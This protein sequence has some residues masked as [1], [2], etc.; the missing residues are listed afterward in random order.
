MPFENNYHALLGDYSATAACLYQIQVAEQGGNFAGHPQLLE[1]LGL[2]NQDL[3]RRL[4][5]LSSRVYTRLQGQALPQEGPDIHGDFHP[6]DFSVEDY[7][8]GQLNDPMATYSLRFQAVLTHIEFF[9][10]HWPLLS[11]EDLDSLNA[12]LVAVLDEYDVI[13]EALVAAGLQQYA[14]QTSF[15]NSPDLLLMAAGSEG[16]DGTAAGIHLRWDFH[17]EL[18]RNHLPKGDYHNATGNTVGFNRPD[19]YVRL[20]RT[21]YVD[22]VQL[23]LDLEQARPVI[24]WARRRWTYIIN[25]T[26]AGKVLSSRI[27]LTFNDANEYQALAQVV[28]PAQE[29]YTFLQAYDGLLEITLH[30]KPAYR[31]GVQF[32]KAPGAPT[33]QFKLELHSEM[34]A[35]TEPAI[36]IRKT[37]STAS[38][39]TEY[40]TGDNLY[41]AVLQKTA[42][43]SLQKLFIENYH[44]FKASRPSSSW[45]TLGDGFALSVHDSTV[46][47][48]LENSSFTIN[49][50]WPQ[51][52]GGTKVLSSSYRDKWNLPGENPETDP[53]LKT[54]VE[55]Y[56]LLSEKDPRAIENW[57]DTGSDE[58]IHSIK[59][60]YL[61]L[62]K[63][64]ALD[65]HMARMLGMGYIDTLPEAADGQYIYQMQYLT[66]KSAGA[67]ELTQHE[68]MSLPTGPSDMRLPQV[69]RIR[70]LQYQL[71]AG[72]GTENLGNVNNQGYAADYQV[73]VVNIGREH[74]SE[75]T[76][77]D[78]F[79]T[80]DT[81]A[82]YD[83]F[84]H[85]RPVMY[86]IEYRKDEQLEYVKPEI[87]AAKMSGEV[88]YAYDAA[89]A[90]PHLVPETIP[91]MDNPDSLFV[92]LVNQ[93][94]I[95][96][97]ALYGINL[98]SRASELSGETATDTT[99]FPPQNTL[100]PPVDLTAQYIQAEETLLFTTA[101]EQAWLKG[102]RNL[103][104]EGEQDTHFTRICFNHVDVQEITGSLPEDVQ[105][106]DQVQV[107]FR[108]SQPLEIKGEVT[109]LSFLPDSSGHVVVHTGGYEQLDGLSISPAIAPA[110]FSRFRDSILTTTEGQFRVIAVSS[111]GTS[112]PLLTVERILDREAI[113]V[114]SD[115]NRYAAK[116]VLR[117]PL[118]GSRF[119]L[120]ENMGNYAN[121]TTLTHPINLL[122]LSDPDQPVIEAESTGRNTV[123]Y[124]VG[125]LHGPALVVPQTDANN[126]IM[127]G[128]FRVTYQP[129]I[130][131]PTHPQL[132]PPYRDDQNLPSAPESGSSPH[133][134][135]YKGVLRLATQEN[136]AP[137]K[138]L[139]VVRILS[140]TPK[141]TLLAYDPLPE[142]TPIQQSATDIDYINGVNFHPGYRAYL[143][144]EAAPHSFNQ[145]HL[146]PESSA[147]D[148]RTLLGVQT[149]NTQYG[150][151]SG[152]SSP[153]ILLA[154]QIREPQQ[155]AA[156]VIYGAKVRPDASGKASF[157]FDTPMTD[158]IAGNRPKPFGMV[159]YRTHHE[160]VLHALYTD[161]TV[162]NILN[163]TVAYTAEQYLN[164]I[165]LTALPEVIGFPA[166][167][168]PGI[169]PEG[170]TAEILLDR[171][172]NAIRATLMP[173]TEQVPMLDYVNTGYQT[174]NTQPVIR[175][176]DGGL[177]SPNDPAFKPFPM[178]RLLPDNSAIRFTDYN[179]NASARFWYFYASAE[180]TMELTPGP[181]STFAGPISVLQTAALPVPTIR[182]VEMQAGN[183]ANAAGLAINFHLSA[184]SNQDAITKLR[185]YRTADIN[186]LQTFP[187]QASFIEV[188]WPAG[189]A[190]AVTDNLVDVGPELLGKTLYY[191]LVAIR[192]IINEHEELEDI[193]SAGSK[194]IPVQ[195][196]D[197][198][199]PE[200][201]ILTYDESANTL[202]WQP[203][204]AIAKYSLYQQNARG[205]WKLMTVIATTDLEAVTYALPQPLNWT[206]DEGRALYYRFKVTVENSSGLRNTSDRVLTL[207]DAQV[208]N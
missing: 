149:R 170:A 5:I 167:D 2:F 73:R 87:T 106:P 3:M 129:G 81:A 110:D 141:L 197:T 102:R 62:L 179:L 168:K 161:S 51:Y 76:A 103:W 37:L 23:I 166:P 123:Q 89:A 146:L 134:E 120:V 32:S 44:D 148:K 53:A 136:G 172:R 122:D 43:S 6:L 54:L 65:Y 185:L 206:D 19:D 191:Q 52:N 31:F 8:A 158:V 119:T 91:V 183:E 203:T 12:A 42:G 171:Y 40:F 152:V 151:T 105:K 186:Q 114:Q 60:S 117:A 169:Q 39:L 16:S 13:Q 195:L 159:F 72:S 33:S 133:V 83:L 75:E 79:A 77:I 1:Q 84:T 150:F 144:P 78:F 145:A 27:R 143:F 160:E 98:F 208:L 182:T 21:P 198:H 121:W 138:S 188:S 63:L 132:N 125:G 94:G 14:C 112:E 196:L 126:T 202:L 193:V 41:R 64:S 104:K 153:A 95:H 11:Q 130:T 99:I 96:R 199:N 155:P 25:L 26:I 59:T 15:R 131:L 154:R 49:Q 57:E 137:K 175:N 173:L 156:P 71:P 147:N 174:E 47:S 50:K 58:L 157:T 142:N 97:Y 30:Q 10:Q 101:Q 55:Q 180:V 164:L 100:R 201:P 45:T 86:G 207:G 124:L 74:F 4:Y 204:V 200:A 113:A 46:F 140:T 177:L 192:T 22:P 92:H 69:P 20:Y 178:V 93:G 205:H 61:D 7:Y 48:Q 88:Y 66:R 135:W 18:G 139:E 184:F 127:P 36:G 181:V 116:E 108:E 82:D 187:V 34:P 176:I 189:S 107:F 68:Y 162:Q 109:R 24:D 70:P 163:Q 17:Q 118:I 67:A 80:Q 56:L 165:N 85:A 28:N 35:S 190:P 38:S 9:R 29:S 194:V 111:G 128:L 90:T 115:E